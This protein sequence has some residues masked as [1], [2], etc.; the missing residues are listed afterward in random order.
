MGAVLLRS[1][2]PSM[3]PKQIINLR[4]NLRIEQ[5]R[6]SILWNDAAKFCMVDDP[7]I[8][9]SFVKTDENAAYTP[10]V[11]ESTIARDCL[12]VLAGGCKQWLTPGPNS[13][14][15]QWQPKA[16]LSPRVARW[17]NDCTQRAEP[18]LT[19]SG[20]YEEMHVCFAQLG[21]YGTAGFMMLQ[22]GEHILQ[23][24]SMAPSD[25]LFET[26]VDGRA[27]RVIMHHER[28]PAQMVEQFPKTCPEEIRAEA[29]E[30][31]QGKY[32]VLHCIYKRENPPAPRYD[33]DPEGMAF[34]SCWI[35]V[36]SEVKLHESGFEEMP[37]FVPRWDKWGQSKY[38][39]GP[40]MLAKATLDGVN[41]DERVL[42]VLGHLQVE[43]RI[44]QKVNAVG[45]LDLTPGGITQVVD[46]DEASEWVTNGRYDV[47]LKQVERK[48]EAVRRLF[49]T[50][51]FQQLAGIEREM[52]KYEVQ[53]RQ[54]E[55]A[56][57]IA[58]AMSRLGT[59]L[60]TP[61]LQRIF[62]QLFRAGVFAPPPMEIFRKDTA[63]QWYMHNPQAI[64]SNRMSRTLASH[65]N[66]AFA[67]AMDRVLPLAQ[68]DPSLLDEYDFPRIF[69]DLDTAD[70]MPV[71]WRRSPE[72]VAALRE[73]R[74]QA[75]QA[76][77]A[78][79]ALLDAAVKQPAAAA[80]LIG[81]A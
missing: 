76:A 16:G 44:K 48:E 15:W 75:A 34:G 56:A 61:V 35:G 62:M 22:G 11:V 32:E 78:Q 8:L 39:F 17:L 28:T 47:G 27:T 2:F 77:Q 68:A 52:T 12:Q 81:A 74:A 31:K 19:R 65:K 14:W 71:Q 45:A 1:F 49:H 30:N 33:G 67:G 38:G 69:E 66:R 51:L 21:V 18:F 24:Q 63:G 7:R 64:Q 29:R 43:P 72:A 70:G 3:T 60:I 10:P 23:P 6:W 58:P 50:H 41:F 36:K 4:D 80:Q 25:F 59:E 9:L 53:Q 40:A 37:F 13:G 42:R 54:E 73:A 46:M 26:A 20:F 79:Q 55:A 5:S 57:G